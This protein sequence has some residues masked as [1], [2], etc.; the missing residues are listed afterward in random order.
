MEAALAFQIPLSAYVRFTPDGLVVLDKYEIADE[1]AV[2]LL[3]ESEDP[4]ALLADMVEIGARVLDRESTGANV[5]FVRNEL[6]KVGRDM[7]RDFSDKARLVAEFFSKKVDEVFS[8]S[9]TLTRALEKHFSE[10]SSTAVQ[11]QV[12]A[13]I[14]EVTARSREDLVRQFSAAD[15]NNPLAG[16]QR[17]ALHSIKTAA[18]QQ[19]AHLREMNET[20]VGLRAELAA[21][22]A[23]KERRE[24]VAAAEERGAA[25]GRTYEEA[26]FEAVDA[27]AVSRG[28]DC[29]AVGDTRGEGGRKGDVVVAIDACAG[30][31]R[32]RIV[33]EAKDRKLSKNQALEELDGAMATRSADF[34]IL[35]V[36]SEDELPARTHPLREYNGDKL[37]VV[38]DPE[39]GSRLA[40]EVAYGLARARVLMARDE[41]GGLDVAAAR[42]EVERALGAMED[43]RRIKSQL[44]NATNGIEA[45]RGILDAMANGVRAHLAALDAL[46]VVEADA[47]AADRL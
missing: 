1:T 9:G 20:I 3:R 21:L 43:V 39:D 34:G 13:V 42:A 26:V 33:F 28:D 38:Y 45:A 17:A 35:V 10:E 31:A 44:T 5:E 47:P 46:L 32:G 19:H 22:K 18:D 41:A 16:F 27:I 40:L 11:H 23:E 6:E 2:R 36:P 4:G 29:D 12:R 8:D 15:G 30:P 25:K 24:D 7:D 14:A 37:F